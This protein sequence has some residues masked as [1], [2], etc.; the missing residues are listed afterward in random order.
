VRWYRLAAAQGYA[1]AQY[2]L[3]TMYKDG[4]GVP[5]NYVEAHKWFNLATTTYNSRKYDDSR[6]DHDDAVKARDVVAARMTPAQI[7]ESQ[8]LAREWKK[9]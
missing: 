3:G 9:Q 8:K 4:Q 6:Y 5:Q 1:D 2:D 7:A